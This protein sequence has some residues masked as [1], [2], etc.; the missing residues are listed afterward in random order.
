MWLLKLLFLL[1]LYSLTAI[2]GNGTMLLMAVLATGWMLWRGESGRKAQ[3]AARQAAKRQ[4]QPTALALFSAELEEIEL[5][6]EQRRR[7][8][9]ALEQAREELAQGLELSAAERDRLRE[10]LWEWLD[11][12]ADGGLGAP[13]WRQA[14]SETPPPSPPPLET[15]KP[16]AE[17]LWPAPPKL[18]ERVTPKSH[19]RQAT[20]PPTPAG[21]SSPEL[22]SP[23]PDGGP[24]AGPAPGKPP[25]TP[26]PPPA[27]SKPDK[28]GAWG[29][30][31]RFLPGKSFFSDLL[32]PFLWQNIGWFI[33]G[34]LAVSGSI[35]LIT[36]TTG[37]YKALA[38]LGVLS[39]YALLFIFGGYAFRRYRPELRLAADILSII[40][41]LLI[42]VV[43]SAA[44]R[45]LALAWPHGWATGFSLTLILVIW[46]GFGLAARLAAG[47]L[48]RNL[49]GE[50]AWL[51]ML[52]AGLQLLA[53]LV[54]IL[55]SSRWWLLPA[56]HLTLLLLLA[57]S[58]H[59]FAADWLRQWFVDRAWL[60]AHAVGSLIF[61]AALSFA[62][63]T[64]AGGRDLPEG[65]LGLF[66]MA[67]N[68]LLWQA[69]WYLKVWRDQ[70]PRLDRLDFLIY[71]LLVPALLLSWQN[72]FMLAATLALG[73]LIYAAMLW[74]YL[75]LPPLYLAVGCLA[76][77]YG[78]L[79][80]QPFP[81]AWH[82]LL[83]LPGL[84]ALL[85]LQRLA[86]ARRSVEL[87]RIAYRLLSA[88]VLTLVV[89]SLLHASPG[90]LG[91]ITALSASGL[92]LL[93]LRD[94]ADL[95][96]A[97]TLEPGRGYLFTALCVLSLAYAPLFLSDWRGQFVLG[98]ALL[99]AIWAWLG[100]RRS[101]PGLP[102]AIWLNSGLAV[103][104]A[105]LLL[106][107]PALWS[108]LS[109]GLLKL[110]GLEMLLPPS[111]LPPTAWWLV[112]PLLNGLTLL[113]IGLK[114]R[115]E[116]LVG[117]GLFL[118]LAI[119]GLG[120]ALYLPG[121]SPLIG[122]LA[123]GFGAWLALRLL[124]KHP[125]PLAT[126]ATPSRLLGMEYSPCA[127]PWLALRRPLMLLLWALWA[128]LLWRLALVF[129]DPRA[130]PNPAWPLL[131][132]GLLGLLLAGQAR[133]AGLIP[134]SLSAWI[135]GL[136]FLLPMHFVWL[137]AQVAGYSLLLWLLGAFWP[138][139]ADRL[140]DWLD[141]RGGWPAPGGRQALETW[142]LGGVYALQFGVWVVC[143][144]YLWLPRSPDWPPLSALIFNAVFFG[145]AA[146]RHPR[147]SLGYGLPLALGL[148]MLGSVA[149]LG[150]T[151]PW[152]LLSGHGLTPWLAVLS[153][154]LA[155]LARRLDSAKRPEFLAR[156]PVRIYRRPL[157]HLAVVLYL[158]ALFDSLWWWS[159]L[160]PTTPWLVVWTLALLGLALAPLTE[161]GNR[162]KELRGAG[163]PLLWGAAWV[164]T[165][166]ALLG[167][168][169]VWLG[170]I[171]WAFLLW[172]GSVHG[173]PYWNQRRPAWKFATDLWPALSLL[174]LLG[175]FLAAWS[176]PDGER[177]PLAINLWLAGAHAWL[178]WRVTRWFWLPAA[179]AL[180]LLLAGIWTDYLILGHGPWGVIGLILWLNFLLWGACRLPVRSWR[181]AL[182]AGSALTLTGLTL[183]LLFMT[184]GRLPLA[185]DL[186]PRPAEILWL[187]LLLPL[188]WWHLSIGSPERDYP[189]H[190]LAWSL[191]PGL[192]L[193]AAWLSPAGWPLIAPSFVLWSLA[194]LGL[195]TLSP[196]LDK[197][198]EFWLPGAAL[199]S[200]LGLGLLDS[201]LHWQ[202]VLIT[203][204][205]GGLS[206]IRAWR[207]NDSNWWWS[208]LALL[209]LSLHLAWPT[210]SPHG[211]SLGLL[212][213]LAWQN[214]LL[215]WGLRITADFLGA[216]DKPGALESRQA[217]GILIGLALLAWLGQPW[218]IFQGEI[219][220]FGPWGHGV[221]LLSGGLLLAWWWREQQDEDSR[222]YGAAL[223]LGL[224]AL[225]LRLLWWGAQPLMTG[226]TVALLAAGY[227]LLAAHYATRSR[228]LY[229]L[230][231]L[232]PVLALFSVP[233]HLGSSQAS[234]SLLAAG[235]LYL[236]L[237]RRGGHLSIYLGLLALNLALYLWVP[238][239]AQRWDLLQLYTV[240]AALT[241]LLMLELHWLELRRSTRNSARLLA[242]GLLYVSAT[243]DVFA[244]PA[245]SVFLLALILGLLGV[246]LGIALRV[247]AFLF[248]GTLFLMFN[249]MSQLIQ[250]A[251]EHNLIK[252]LVLMGVGS[253]ILGG[254]IAFS[255]QRE[256][257]LRRLR[258]IRADLAE[259]E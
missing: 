253:V 125:T 132:H 255:L 40:G 144:I 203:G 179:G 62:H 164:G 242:L 74:H 228:A 183:G 216:R 219:P 26:L 230:T 88:L 138:K 200:L 167:E 58:L 166:S 17:R 111:P 63:L 69:G 1:L 222:V 55:E 239:L 169:G 4:W 178:W 194:L 86:L 229:R 60:S 85:A 68:G 25:E 124:P 150:Q 13:P 214:S 67:V 78:L 38:I 9:R 171:S 198:A 246:V 215:A 35:M 56:G 109:A 37:Y 122:L 16:P 184:L 257:I 211:A 168:V 107:P 126:P 161:P 241:V 89:W 5:P 66:L 51:F 7:L 157:R 103:I 238:G 206:L 130:H 50:H 112:P 151:H 134:L 244:S 176:L 91:L 116:H 197:I 252:A 127:H 259:W 20:P 64:W 188:S 98:L 154:L 92:I 192:C 217:A 189:W 153:G 170:L 223:I 31:S 113:A 39:L 208:G 237:P 105:G 110:L 18:A 212:P 224:S 177:W 209:T 136:I 250:H 254:M 174:Y 84:G 75:T 146:W 205:L 77:V 234:L 73:G 187:S 148:G 162:G 82:F 43:L 34:F 108:G 21:E 193:L 128:L 61:A 22:E 202:A 32:W 182:R 240:P 191:P 97:D 117:L 133:R 141:W 100:L 137:P 258:V 245:L 72:D 57:W 220:L 218:L 181:A 147:E 19:P 15:R 249:V 46:L 156:P 53:P 101:P 24:E 173:L 99:A 155:L 36:E 185:G 247:R 140:W 149:Y 104:F 80:L 231:L 199:L 256:A 143:L 201:P 165:G 207:Q 115:F 172:A 54:E 123:A 139:W 96:L 129:L 210:A 95:P 6:A 71:A 102:A 29:K 47:S 119:S 28:L 27:E 90:W 135:A 142:L 152:L 41:L 232:L 79:I 121:L 221:G 227:A 70:Y 33:A 180:V 158:F 186:F 213:W 14:E 204:L 23:E 83:G 106:S 8:A 2:S 131:G 49:Q 94:L 65:Y 236:L 248:T 251:P 81:A 163:L 45:V 175:G 160:W 11:Q 235:S 114:R 226:D 196:R 12:R 52:L 76:G 118:L 195:G 44:A 48:A 159:R 225:H 10:A 87:A 59:R 120:K 190:G 42:P 93:A 243:W 233:W 145:L 3:K 30:I